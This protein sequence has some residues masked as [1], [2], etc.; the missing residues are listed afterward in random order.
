MNLKEI[1]AKKD[2]IISINEKIKLLKKNN[3][4]SNKNTIKDDI[5]EAF[6]E[7]FFFI[8]FILLNIFCYKYI[9]FLGDTISVILSILFSIIILSIPLS[10]YELFIEKKIKKILNKKEDYEIKLYEYLKNSVREFAENI[11]EEELEKRLNIFNEEEIEF[12]NKKENENLIYIN[13]KNF[14]KEAYNYIKKNQLTNKEYSELL[15]LFDK[16]DIEI[17]KEKLEDA[18]ELSKIKNKTIKN[19]KVLL[20]I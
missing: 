14:E 10:I 20:S 17:D 13:K 19:N 8:V 18:F 5:K 4:Y 2:T 6:V 11:T 16:I 7:Y 9:S 12:I 1:I 15:I 3:L